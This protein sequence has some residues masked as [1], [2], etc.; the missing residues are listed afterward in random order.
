MLVYKYRP[1]SERTQQILTN[2]S[3]FFAAPDQLNDPLDSSIDIESE[4][5]AV[6]SNVS[7]NDHHP[8]QRKTFLI[9]LLNSSHQ[10]FG[11]DGGP[12]SMNQALQ[13]FIQ[14]RGILSLSRTPTSPLLWS[15]YSDSHRGIC[16]GFDRES[17]TADF[18]SLN[19]DF[20]YCEDI[21]YA[22]KPPYFDLFIELGEKL[23]E[24]CRPWDNAKYEP[25]VADNFYSEQIA[26]LCHANL[27]YKSSK[28]SYEEEV[29]VVSFSPGL[30]KFDPKSLR[31][32]I[33]GARSSESD[34]ET[35]LTALNHPDFVH[36]EVKKVS[37]L[38]GTF[39]FGVKTIDD[40]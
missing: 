17:L 32:I 38:A 30:M 19:E 12:I 36:V 37:H 21:T 7:R 26:R 22:E 23:G 31:Q 1:M 40:I 10:Y 3:L 34:L 8:Q 25:S 18:E 24:F 27:M 33:L 16:L 35:I 5:Q 4:Y 9:H 15:H 11:R 13:Q 2:C 29:R 39:E 20:S 28:W 6:L 14:S